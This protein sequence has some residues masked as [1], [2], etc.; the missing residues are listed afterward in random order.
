MAKLFDGSSDDILKENHRSLCKEGMDEAQAW[1]VVMKRA[2]K[3]KA[4]ERAI[5]GVKA[6]PR[7]KV[8]VK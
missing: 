6:K 2:N 4:A 5:T 1:S 7:V 3:A 8:K